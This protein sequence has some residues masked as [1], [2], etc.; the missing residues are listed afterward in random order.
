MIVIRFVG[1][2][3][4]TKARS[5]I[6]IQLHMDIKYELEKNVIKKQNKGRMRTVRTRRYV[7]VHT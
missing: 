6:T 2:A 1:R 3:N 5:V 7:L 4:E